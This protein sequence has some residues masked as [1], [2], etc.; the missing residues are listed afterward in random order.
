MQQQDD[1][2][3][4]RPRANRGAPAISPLRAALLFGTAA[5]ALALVAVSYLDRS[6]QSRSAQA[7][8]L[9]LDAITTGSIGQPKTYIV[10][11]SV[12]QSS[13]EAVCVIRPDGTRS[14]E[15]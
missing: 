5:I 7:L 9:G 1:W 15:C 13:P 6:S 8:P 14:G 11:K 10:R 12:L 3:A 2:E 4:L